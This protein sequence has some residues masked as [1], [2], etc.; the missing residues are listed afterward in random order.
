MS[1][2]RHIYN[3]IL[4]LQ[5]P[6]ALV[7][8]GAQPET[9]QQKRAAQ[10]SGF[11]QVFSE[12]DHK[13]ENPQFPVVLV[14]NG[15][16][17]VVPTQLMSVTKLVDWRLGLCMHQL[18]QAKALWEEAQLDYTQEK[19]YDPEFIRVI[20]T[21][22]LQMIGS[23][24]LLLQ[25]R[26]DRATG[27][28]K[29]VEATHL[30]PDKSFG[31]EFTHRGSGV[32]HMRPDLP[33][34]SKFDN[35]VTPK[36]PAIS[37]P[38]LMSPPA[39]TTPEVIA[40]SSDSDIGAGQSAS[41]STSTS[42]S[43]VVPTSQPIMGSKVIT[44]TTGHNRGKVTGKKRA[45]RHEV[46]LS[47]GL[48]PTN[49]LKY[50]CSHPGCT[51]KEARKNDLDDHVF[52]IHQGGR[53]PCPH[54]TKK[55]MKKR[56]MVSHVRTIHE[57]KKKCVCKL[58]N[59]TWSSNDYGNLVGHLFTDHGIGSELKCLH[60]SKAFYNE[61]SY[62]YHIVHAHEAK[63]FQCNECRRWFKL[64]SRLQVHWENYH[65]QSPQN[66]CHICGHTFSDDK[67]LKQHVKKHSEEEEN[68]ANILSN[69][70]NALHKKKAT[71]T[72]SKPPCEESEE[73]PPAEESQETPP[74]EESQETP[75]VTHAIVHSAPL[76]ET[77]QS[78]PS[79][80]TPQSAPLQQEQELPTFDQKV[81]P[82]L[83]SLPEERNIFSES[84]LD[85]IIS[86]NPD[87]QQSSTDTELE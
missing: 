17:H 38:A 8:P 10:T 63:T 47:Q 2:V 54:C 15:I 50:V 14:S 27:I 77:A 78:A 57:G 59:C 80:D 34:D 51:H 29:I 48:K 24:R 60:C 79:E 33:Q 86:Q 64:K 18:N 12:I 35:P 7:V 20:D 4:Y 67:S 25:K 3:N 45:R 40:I 32:A 73:T 46:R 84:Y 6:I 37:A 16:H 72:V 55:F 36:T 13:M 26:A 61:R 66:M 41:Q 68:K 81:Q 56:S 58:P 83:P 65:K 75:G 39:S 23:T 5:I 42:S 53:H 43:Q 1:C 31:S 21:N 70:D 19:N 52:V 28:C 71:A 9:I 11:V 30:G 87:F 69:I 22:F 44:V 85:A 49:E 82:D 62:D 76:Q 74:V